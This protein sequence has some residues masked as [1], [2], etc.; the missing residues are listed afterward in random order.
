M[1]DGLHC[2]GALSV[3][4]VMATCL[5]SYIA[6]IESSRRYS[7]NTV[8]SY[9]RDIESLLSF[10]GTDSAGFEPSLLEA[11]DIREWIISLSER[12]IKPTSINRMLSACNSFYRYMQRTG[13]V[14]ANPFVKISSLKT[15][16]PLPAF[17]PEGRM[18]PLAGELEEEIDGGGSFREVRDALV[19]LFLYSTGIRLAELVAVNRDDFGRGFREL[20]VTGKGGK[21]RVVPVL[22]ELRDKVLEYLAII[23]REN[24]CK[25]GEKALFL[26]NEGKRISRSTVYRIVRRQL[27]AAGVQGKRSPHVLR[28]TFATHLMNGGADLREIQELLGHSSLSTTQVYTHNSIARLKEVYDEAHPRGGGGGRH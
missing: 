10:I 3:T 6:Y 27:A 19:V 25:F 7:Q 13:M 23:R 26:T 11:D 2:A 5:D 12:G 21:E 18:A 15:P 9:R 4:S 14:T 20:R 16:K 28:H 24:I 22:P 8:K 1:V 17:V